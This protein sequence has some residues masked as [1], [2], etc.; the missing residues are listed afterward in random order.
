[1]A[2]NDAVFGTGTAPC[3][4]SLSDQLF[5]IGSPD[6]ASLGFLRICLKDAHLLIQAGDTVDEALCHPH[7]APLHDINEEPVCPRPFSLDFEQPSL[8]ED[9]IKELIWREAAKFN[10]DPTH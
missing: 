9:N 4:I 7:L 1:M 3:L 5:L 8:T 6:D 10:P 2:N